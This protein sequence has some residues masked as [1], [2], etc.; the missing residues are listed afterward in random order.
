MRKTLFLFFIVS[1]VGYAKGETLRRFEIG[2]VASSFNF[3]DVT[4][5]SEMR[6]EYGGR[7]VVNIHPR[8]AL[9][10]QMT[11]S[12]RDIRFDS[13]SRGSGHLKCNVWR[14]EKGLLNIFGVVG[15]GY[16]H[17]EAE[18]IGGLYHYIEKYR[19]IGVDYGAGI[20]VSPHKR[21]A[22]RLDLKDF[23]AGKTYKTQN[24]RDSILTPQYGPR[25]WNHHLDL[26]AAFMFRF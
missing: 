20:E 5:T 23:Y 26:N 13:S 24:L 8:I 7:F 11:Y 15:P 9:E 16:M 10:Y 21:F 14:S 1:M 17:E 12:G 22:I 25:Y 4:S 18:Y 6:G 3:G 19:S 2:F